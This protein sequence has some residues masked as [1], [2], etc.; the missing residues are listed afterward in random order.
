MAILLSLNPAART[1]AADNPLSAL[2]QKWGGR[3]R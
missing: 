1:V 3:A 2:A